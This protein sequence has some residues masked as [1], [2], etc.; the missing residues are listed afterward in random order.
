MADMKGVTVRVPLDTYEALRKLAFRD[1]RSMREYTR[2]VLIK[3]AN[4]HLDEGVI[5]PRSLEEEAGG[6][7]GD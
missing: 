4:E 6:T 5:T 7:D 3:H 1:N 2:V